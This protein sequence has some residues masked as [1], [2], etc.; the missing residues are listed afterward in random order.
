MIARDV[1]VVRRLDEFSL[2]VV[3]GRFSIVLRSQ[4]QLFGRRQVKP[5]GSILGHVSLLSG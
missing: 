3:L 4:L 1:R 2:L 5:D